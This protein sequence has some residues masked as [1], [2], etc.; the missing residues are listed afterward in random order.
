MMETVTQWVAR[1]SYP[2]F[3][4]A[5]GGKAAHQAKVLRQGY[6]Y[7]GYIRNFDKLL[8]ALGIDDGPEA[9]TYFEGVWRHCEPQTVWQ[10]HCGLPGK[11]RRKARITRG[12]P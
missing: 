4:E 2:R 6:G 8:Q 5:L 1:R 10:S 11:T 9:L 3:L 7:S 12:Y